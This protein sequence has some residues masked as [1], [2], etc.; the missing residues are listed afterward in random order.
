MREPV[1]TIASIFPVFS[2]ESAAGVG[3]SASAAE[4][5]SP[6]IAPVSSTVATTRAGLLQNP[7]DAC[8]TPP[9]TWRWLFIVLPIIVIAASDAPSSPRYGIRRPIMGAL[10][11]QEAVSK[12][13]GRKYAY[14]SIGVR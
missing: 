11:F 5:A 7:N 13:K 6:A 3:V 9:S 8:V 1:T 4:T 12:S 14:G 2:G 10:S